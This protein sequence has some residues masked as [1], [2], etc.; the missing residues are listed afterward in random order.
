[1]HIGIVQRRREIVE[2][3]AL[4][5]Q[6]TAGDVIQLVDLKVEQFSKARLPLLQLA[7]CDF[8]LDIGVDGR[9]NEAM[10]AIG[11]E[12]SDKHVCSE[13]GK[14]WLCAVNDEPDW[15]EKTV[16]RKHGSWFMC[17]ERAS[18]LSRFEVKMMAFAKHYRVSALVFAQWYVKCWDVCSFE[19]VLKS[20]FIRR[21]CGTTPRLDLTDAPQF[22]CMLRFAD[23]FCGMLC[24]SVCQCEKG[25]RVLLPKIALLLQ[26]CVNASQL[27]ELVF[28][29][30]D[31]CSMLL[32]E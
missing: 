7:Q 27:F 9:C 25:A 4:R 13:A 31:S 20:S 8:E 15:L 16:L 30:H 14:L 32:S 23:V 17:C 24:K 22:I 10:H 12:V 29:Q 1:M 19:N 28:L 3:V 21:V 6:R 11:V 26:Q 5:I 18:L 2:V